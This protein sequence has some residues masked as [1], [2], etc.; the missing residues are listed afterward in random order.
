[1]LNIIDATG[2]GMQ[3]STGTVIAVMAVPLLV[4]VFFYL[5]RSIGIYVLA[6]RA[7]IK[8]AWLG[9]VPCV[10][11]YPLI[12]LLSN[13][14]DKFFGKFSNLGIGLTTVGVAL[15]GILTVFVSLVKIIPLLGYYLQGGTVSLVLGETESFF[16]TGQDFVNPFD[17][18]AMATILNIVEWVRTP[19]GLFALVVEVFMYISLFKLYWAN[20]YILGTVLSVLGL[21]GIMVFI[22]R[23][24]QSIDFNEYLR[25]R[26]SN[27]YNP[28]GPNPY[29]APPQNPT[30]NNNDDP[31]KDFTQNEEP[32]SEFD[33]DKDNK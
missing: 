32:F 3:V 31:F 14:N 20:N 30:P 24:K 19:L 6:K 13:A 23:K 10:W 27:V 28:Y 5:L 17:T 25:S 15:S 26:Y 9:F 29:G 18:A 4:R 1:M 11:I 21:F 12:K 22:I 33:K 7:G 16:M 8:Q 2:F